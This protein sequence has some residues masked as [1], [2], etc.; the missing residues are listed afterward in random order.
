VFGY[1]FSALL[2]ENGLTPRARPTHAHTQRSEGG[3]GLPVCTSQTVH[4]FGNE[5]RKKDFQKVDRN[6]FR[7]ETVCEDSQPPKSPKVSSLAS[8]SSLETCDKVNTKIDPFL[9]LTPTHRHGA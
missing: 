7:T 1:R 9:S 4:L 6:P 8:E 5:L 3:R 2:F